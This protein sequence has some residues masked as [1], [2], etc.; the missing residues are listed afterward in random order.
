[1]EKEGEEEDGTEKDSHR[2]RSDVAPVDEGGRSKH[3]EGKRRDREYFVV[4]RTIH[5]ARSIKTYG[6]RISFVL[7]NSLSCPD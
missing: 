1:M 7:V 6:S 5:V 2:S 4:E 3:R